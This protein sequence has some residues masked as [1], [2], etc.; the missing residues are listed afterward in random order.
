METDWKLKV[1]PRD[2]SWFWNMVNEISFFLSENVFST[3]FYVEKI[4]MLYFGVGKS[5]NQTT[6]RYPVIFLSGY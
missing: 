6:Q 4:K 5:V 2:D 3:K 1:S